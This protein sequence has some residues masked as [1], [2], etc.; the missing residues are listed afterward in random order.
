MSRAYLL[1]PGA[2]SRPT[3]GSRYNQHLVEGLSARGL[4]IEPIEVWG[5][6]PGPHHLA[7]QAV[8][9]ALAALPDH[10]TVIIDGLILGG[11]P[12]AIAAESERLALIALIH[13]PLAD[14]TG[15]SPDQVRALLTSEAQALQCCEQVVVT[16]AFTGRR[17]CALDLYTGPVVVAPPGVSPRPLATGRADHTA[18][19]NLLCVASLTPRKGQRVLVQAL[20]K[21]SD[22]HWQAQLV[23]DDQL[24][25]AYAQSVRADCEH[26]GLS[27][28]I[29]LTGAVSEPALEQTYQQADVFVLP[30]HYEGYGMVITEAIA[31]G[32]PVITT[33]GGALAETLPAGAGLSVPP[34]DP[35]AL[36]K[37]L[38]DWMRDEHLRETLHA[39]AVQ[40]RAQ[41]SHWTPTLD[42]WGALLT[43]QNRN[44]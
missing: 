36:S 32:L 12:E 21:L 20:A 27:T 40:A 31:Y 43:G 4:S 41:L 29:T 24:D 39:G 8:T 34:N 38:T 10:A 17:L 37:A 26:Y 42:Q 19:L 30:S 5:P 35:A 18:P 23:G 6:F 16:S 44:V 22:R 15:L 14:E 2:L 1:T 9:D 11:L 13:H 25:P 3:G 33:S 7:H 28:S